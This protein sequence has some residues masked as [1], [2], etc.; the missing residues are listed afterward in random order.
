MS[1]SIREYILTDENEFYRE[2]HIIFI[3]IANES[4]D[5]N[6]NKCYNKV[7]SIKTLKET[8][9]KDIDSYIIK[10]RPG[11]MYELK[12]KRVIQI[13]A[14]I[15]FGA[16]ATIAVGAC[17][18]AGFTAAAYNAIAATPSGAL[19]ISGA[20]ALKVSAGALS[21]GATYGS[22][23]VAYGAPIGAIICG[24]TQPDKTYITVPDLKEV[25][26]DH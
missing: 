15:T 24:V 5:L 19:A 2:L 12:K 7:E 17:L 16:A 8:M 4:I 20:G 26:I 25:T 13:A 18:G 22:M 6:I 1:K 21:L 10:V 14:R 23:V 11:V 9:I 3:S